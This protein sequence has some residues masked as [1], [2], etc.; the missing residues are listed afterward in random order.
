L[1]FIIINICDSYVSYY[2][3]VNILPTYCMV[4][5]I[6]ILS[7][8][9][10]RGKLEVPSLRTSLKTTVGEKSQIPPKM[11]KPTYCS[12]TWIF[13]PYFCSKYLKLFYYIILYYIIL[14]YIILYYIILYYITL[15][16]IIL[17][18]II[19][20][21]IT[22]HYIIL[23]YIILYYVILYYFSTRNLVC[24]STR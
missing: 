22:L 20:Y 18:Y 19:L 23:Y 14:Y 17:Y 8:Q 13:P 24:N 10:L 5:Y 15:Y 16:Y 3:I 6:N 9:R 11:H 7:W 1:T 21:Y 12:H 4:V 2:W